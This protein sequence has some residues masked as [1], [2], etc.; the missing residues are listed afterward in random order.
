MYRYYYQYQAE[1]LTA[2]RITVH[3]LLHIVDDI[4]RTGPVWVN[5]SFVMERFCGLL[6]Q[7]IK[8]KRK[9]YACLNRRILHLAQ[10]AKITQ[11][12][13]LTDMLRFGKPPALISTH[14]ETLQA[15]E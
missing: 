10:L 5:W 13:D 3:A 11:R 4:E 12:F 1:R 8:S 15:C 6:G 7:A 14:E 2:C 9:P